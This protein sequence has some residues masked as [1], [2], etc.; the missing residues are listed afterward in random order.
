MSKATA[1]PAPDSAQKPR[2]AQ[3]AA[4]TTLYGLAY[5]P[6]MREMA[7]QVSLLFGALILIRV[8]SLRWPAFTPGRWLLIPL[9]VGALINVYSAHH[10]IAGQDG[11]TALL[12][13]MLGLK[14]LEARQV[15]D[16]RLASM[17]FCFL[18]VSQFL[19]V[20]SSAIALYCFVLLVAN[21][22]LLADLSG[23]KTL[24]V[25]QSLR[26]SFRLVLQALPLTLVLFALFPRL[27]APLWNFQAAE[28]KART[29]IKPWLEPGSVSELV[30][31]GALAFR[32]RFDGPVPS[33]EK[34]YWRGPIAW[35]TDGK[36]WL[37]A[38]PEQFAALSTLPSETS[39]DRISYEVSLDPTG[40]RWLF[41][42]DLPTAAPPRDARMTHDF[43]V[44]A[45]KEITEATVYRMTS[46]PVYNTGSLSLEEEV[47]G[48]Q[49]PDNVTERMRGLVADWETRAGSPS[50]LV[51]QGLAFF[52]R[53]SFHYTLLPPRLGE[54]PTD[55]FLFETRKGFCEHYA[56]SFALLMR[57]AGIPSRVVMG[58]MGGERNPLGGHLIVR[59]SDAHAWVEVW[60]EGRGWVRVDP[61]GAVA[62]WRVERS[63]LL[64]G[65]GSGSPLRFRVHESDGLANLVHGLRLLADAIDEN[66]RHWVLELDHSRQLNMMEHIGLGYLR[67]YGLA[68]AMII[69]AAVVL[70][71]LVLGL[72]REDQE[73][74]LSP[75]ERLYAQF[76]KTLAREG[77]PRRPSEGP[78]D[79]SARVASTRKD[80]GTSANGF[81][82]LYAGVR[83]GVLPSDDEN[84][85]RLRGYL[86][87]LRRLAKKTRQSR[88]GH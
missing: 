32:A 52:N 57:I 58:Y 18:L 71:I 78:L 51:G 42:L 4:I 45:P 1:N 23:T 36:R 40:H 34:L 62:P 14:L 15:R 27:D 88:S 16:V 50:E 46:A 31:D 83:Y 54:N 72:V 19:F 38:E 6:L 3:V 20:Q 86:R 21:F 12:V 55:E 28:Q 70:A 9:T 79:Y 74:P 35:N 17:L 43:Q 87:E 77:L 81:A 60:L 2:T 49:L 41:A 39:G 68:V 13:S 5:L 67:E 85:D 24:A 66:W 22:A 30:V 61:T 80:L 82:R 10:T 47:A 33:P 8:A 29:G 53:E 37:P 65:L 25:S 48:L 84:L 7:I 44:L 11:G 73:S 26:L 75:E 63:D 76:G 56:S 69:G 59:Q 64:A